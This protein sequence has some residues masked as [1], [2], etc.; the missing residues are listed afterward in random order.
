MH[1]LSLERGFSNIDDVLGR[2]R[3]ETSRLEMVGAAREWALDGHTYAHRVEALL[4]TV[5]AR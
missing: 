4:D 3:D 2:F 5:Q 1:Y